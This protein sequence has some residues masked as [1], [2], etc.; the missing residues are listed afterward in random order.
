M[1]KLIKIVL[2]IVLII[3]IL[4]PI[5]SCIG[6]TGTF[7]KLK[8]A[9]ANG[10]LTKNDLTE[11]AYYYQGNDIANEQNREEISLDVLSARKSRKIKRTYK[12][13]IL[14]KR[15]LSNSYIALYAYYGTYNGAVAVGITDDYNDYDLFFYEEYEVGGVIFYNFSETHIRIWIE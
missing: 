11:I 15:W 8:E 7:Y 1:K 9:Y 5:F 12:T 3:A 6:P 13:Q 14:N 10:L 2:P 4:L